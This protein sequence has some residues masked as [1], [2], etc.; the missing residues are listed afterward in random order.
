[1]TIRQGNKSPSFLSLIWWRYV[2]AAIVPIL[3]VDV[4]LLGT[5]LLTNDTA[6]IAPLGAYTKPSGMGLIVGFVLFLH[7]AFFAA[8]YRIIG[9][10]SGLFTKPLAQINL[11]AKRI[12]AGDYYQPS[13]H[14]AVKEL[15]RS[16][17]IIA[18]MG[19][20]LGD[21]HRALLEAQERLNQERALLHALIDSIPDLIFYKNTAGI[22]LGCNKAF[23][24]SMQ[25]DE[26]DIAG[27]SDLDLFPKDVA[28]VFRTKDRQV[29]ASGQPRCDEE[30]LDH[31][32]GR[33]TVIETLKTPYLDS[34]GNILGLIGIC[35]DIDQRKRLEQEL[36]HAKQEAEAAS[37]AKSDFLA[38][39]SHEIR[40]PLNGVLGMT[41]LLLDTRLDERQ[42][43]LAQTAL[44][45]GK[46]LLNIINDILDFSKIESGK[47]ALESIDFDLRR[48]ISDI[49]L[50]FTERAGSK[51][52]LLQVVIPDT[53]PTR[54]FGDPIRLRQVL[55]NLLANAI[56]FTE[57][58]HVMLRISADWITA[59]QGQLK[60]EVSDTG[61]GIAPEA[62]A[63]I[64]EPFAQAT[65][66][67]TR[68]YGGTGLGLAICRQLV[69]LMGGAIGV[70]SAPGQGAS[71]WFR[72]TLARVSTNIGDPTTTPRLGTR[73]RFNARVLVVE[74]N[75]VNQEVARAMLE[76]LG[77]RADIATDGREAVLAAL[78]KTY[79]LVLMDCHMPVLDGFA[80]TAE[81]RQQE[82]N[83]TSRLPV[84]ALT[85]NVAKG[86]REQCLAA[87]MDDYLSKPFDQAQLATVLAKFLR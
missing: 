57:Q 1:M 53:L 17:Q 86:V 29:L 7:I 73:P 20:R 14:V 62:Q 26:R 74:D 84:I 37:R 33:R 43:Q 5:H 64:F 15:D 22:Y 30:W 42:R 81:I 44:R 28:V 6:L 34:A 82:A 45:S 24:D 21:H 9:R 8:L 63:Q 10:V 18:A 54:W 50:L 79:D 31:S 52:L 66:A 39:M 16:V 60:F 56:K 83:G 40:T 47:L 80:A 75:P 27:R 68:Q 67:V 2:P 69:A 55:T 72:L 35:R 76:Q 13:P 78:G 36:A 49:Y 71:F 48:L 61:I 85:A 51:N 19:H 59:E 65:Q 4:L 11:M 25:C 12:G 3:L 41:E 46:G 87:G 58:G 77:C 32:D 23:A 70:D 38:T